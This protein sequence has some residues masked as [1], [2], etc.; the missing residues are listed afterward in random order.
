MGDEKREWVWDSV[1]DTETQSSKADN[2]QAN[3]QPFYLPPLTNT[4]TM[5]SKGGLER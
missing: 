5:Q 4:Q 2:T 1:K 3:R